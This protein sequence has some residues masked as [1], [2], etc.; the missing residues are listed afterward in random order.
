MKK[1][2]QSKTFNYFYKGKRIE[3][4]EGYLG[5]FFDAFNASEDEV[6]ML[7]HD[8]A[9]LADSIEVR[10]DQFKTL[11]LTDNGTGWIFIRE[12][13]EIPGLL[14]EEAIGIDYYNGKEYYVNS[15]LNYLMEYKYFEQHQIN[16]Q[17]NQG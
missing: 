5:Y 16:Q 11:C 3:P 4:S 9:E 10:P 15:G 7:C 6:D 1:D 2:H 14:A 12:K 8:L 13:W 17:T